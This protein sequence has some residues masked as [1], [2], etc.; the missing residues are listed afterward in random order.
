MIAI[1]D[2][3]IAIAALLT[4]GHWLGGRVPQ[5][6]AWVAGLG[7]WAPLGFVALYA[8]ATVA[9]VPGSLLTLAG[10]ALFG[11]VRGAAYS[12]IG[13]TL[14]ASLAF[15]VARYLARG[16]VER[17][18]AK[19]PRFAALDRAVGE[20]GFRIVALLRL[21]PLFPFTLLNYALG[22]T[23]VRFLPYLAA[24]LAMLPGAVL[25]AYSGTA[26]GSLVRLSAGAPAERDAASWVL[27][28][29]GLLATI[30][31]AA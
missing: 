24:S 22:L 5:A 12:L 21:S 31:V 4:L 10:G 2:V 15:L 14:G 3:A 13:A 9:F 26:I 18:L 29:A 8:L 16:A 7:A 6:A 17:R 20:G 30:A 25:Y 28:G 1:F 23:R 11:V 27:L 19:S